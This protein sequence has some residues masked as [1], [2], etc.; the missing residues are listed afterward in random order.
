MAETTTDFD[1]PWE[2]I[3]ER[4]FEDFMAFFFPAAHEAIDWEKSYTFLDKELQQ[5]VREAETGPR[6]VDKLVQVSLKDNEETAWILI[7]LEVQ[8][9]PDSE[10]VHLQLSN[11]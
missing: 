9:Q 2:N 8:G 6:R 1:S 11:I 5:V 4:Y 3:I 7:H 10:D